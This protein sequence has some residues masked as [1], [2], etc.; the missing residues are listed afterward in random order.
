M[1]LTGVRLKKSATDLHAGISIDQVIAR[2]VG[3]L[4]RFP[5]LELSSDATR[6][7]GRVRFWIRLR[8][9]IQSLLELSDNARRCRI[10]SAPGL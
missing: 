2:E 6:R 9:S 1:F 4:T 5:S 7:L 3:H 8:L 10:Q